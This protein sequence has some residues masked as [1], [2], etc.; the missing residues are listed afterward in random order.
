M[1]GGGRVVPTGS[2]GDQVASCFGSGDVNHRDEGLSNMNGNGNID[3]NMNGNA[4]GD[5]NGNGNGSAHFHNDGNEAGSATGMETEDTVAS[6]TVPEVP[7]ARAPP[8][9]T[10]RPSTFLVK[11]QMSKNGGKVF[12]PAYQE[13]V[14]ECWRLINELSDTMDVM[15]PQYL[16][17]DRLGEVSS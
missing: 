17:V 8:D 15:L 16:P 5:M 4:N 14:K 6:E 1:L 13:V 3:I 2:M 9:F 12:E 7:R 10:L 11:Q